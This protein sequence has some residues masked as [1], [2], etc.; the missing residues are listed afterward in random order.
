MTMIRS[1]NGNENLISSESI[2]RDTDMAAEMAT[3][4]KNQLKTNSASAMLAQAN[5][6]SDTVRQLLT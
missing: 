4:M 2:I 3:H 5:Q 6:Q 1:L